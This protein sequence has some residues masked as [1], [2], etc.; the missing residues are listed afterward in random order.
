MSR[1]GLTGEFYL[2]WY[3]HA[4]I[5]AL[6]PEWVDTGEMLAEVAD[7]CARSAR[8]SLDTEADSLHSY[9]HKVC[10]VQVTTAGRHFLVDPLALTPA[11]LRP[12][13][14][15]VACDETSVV[16]H[17]ADYDLRVLDRDHGVRFSRLE[18]TQIMAQ[19]LGLSRTG[20]A[21]LL[22]EELGIKLDKRF[23]RA[24]WGRRP[25]PEGC[26]EYA[27]ADTAFLD[28]L[29][30][31]L[32]Q[33]LEE[34]G[35]WPWALEEFDR[36]M[37]VRFAAAEPDPLAFERIKGARRLKG[38]ARNRLFTLFTW[39]EGLARDK[40]LP[41]FKIVGPSQ[42]LAAAEL[43]PANLDELSRISGLG[44]RFVRRWGHRVL[45][46]LK[47]PEQAPDRPRPNPSQPLSATEKKQ[48]NDLL[49]AR[50]AVAENLG[51]G[52]SLL[53]PRAQATAVTRLKGAQITDADLAAA[54]VNG[55]RLEQLGDTFLTI[56][57]KAS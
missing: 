42:L 56:I 30:M 32:R 51:L 1:I 24:D 36:L 48:L 25:L 14:Q 8:F 29:A 13:W 40:D 23:Q 35:R 16:M 57:R 28:N 50:D 34:L 26:P 37:A 5:E 45:T 11:E 39:R 7:L 10:L 53:C 52:P 15:V 38:A 18:D 2:R 20:L 55:W 19:L 49:K 27:A 31:R 41:P 33:R 4:M 44:P 3:H 6:R 54:G 9:F 12:L 17:G 22:Q 47:T 21:A 43:A 46:C